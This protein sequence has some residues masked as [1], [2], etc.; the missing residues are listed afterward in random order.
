MFVGSCRTGFVLRFS[1]YSVKHAQFF[2]DGREMAGSGAGG[3]NYDF[4]SELPDRLNCSICLF[5]LRNPVQF[6]GCGHR[7][8]KLCVDPILRYV[9]ST[10]RVFNTWFNMRLCVF[11]FVSFRTTAKYIGFSSP[12]ARCPIDRTVASKDKVL[13][14]VTFFL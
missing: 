8:C 2:L 9:V 11:N 6:M 12:Q 1:N 10:V 5:A 13:Y 3:Y 7:F 14:Q 4:V